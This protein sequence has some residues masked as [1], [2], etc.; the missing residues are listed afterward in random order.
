[1]EVLKSQLNKDIVYVL[2]LWLLVVGWTGW[3][4]EI[5]SKEQFCDL[6]SSL[7]KL[8]WSFG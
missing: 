3:L 2:Y 5:P 8:L 4:P 7:A 6:K 1:M